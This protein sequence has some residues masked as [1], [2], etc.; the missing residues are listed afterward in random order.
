MFLACTVVLWNVGRSISLTELSRDRLPY[1]RLAYKI[2][3]ID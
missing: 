1:F 2:L 3:N